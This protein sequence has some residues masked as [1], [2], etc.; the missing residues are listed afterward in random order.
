MQIRS[1]FK[2]AGIALF[3]V[4]LS[5]C[6]DVDMNVAVLGPDTAS[7]TTKMSMDRKLYD[8]GK[9]D[10]SEDDFCTEGDLTLTD[11]AA[12]CTE[13][14]K[15]GFAELFSADD[16]EEPQP[17]ISAAG[18]GL[19][20]VSFPTGALAADFADTEDSDADTDAMMKMAFSGHNI[21][22]TVSGGE[23]TDT[24]MVRAKDG[25]S[26]SLVIDMVALLSGKADLPEQ[27]YAV[28]KLP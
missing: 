14:V 27:S 3:A 4:G 2:A 17:Q 26:A 21:T 8:T 25:H 20:K 13:T 15:G 10:G 28:V 22:L 9:E 6:V 5:G 23:I 19:V 11:S 1:F 18:D 24:N 12:V 16:A 7:V